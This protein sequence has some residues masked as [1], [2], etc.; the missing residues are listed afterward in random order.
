MS[1][2]ASDFPFPHTIGEPDDGSDDLIGGEGESELEDDPG[3]GGPASADDRLAE[4]QARMERI[5]TEARQREQFYQDQLA[6]QASGG[7]AGGGDA[8]DDLKLDDLPDPVEDIGK[9]REQLSARVKDYTTKTAKRVAD[10]VRSETSQQQAFENVWSRFRSQHEDLAE[11]QVLLRAAAM[12]EIEDAQSRGLDPATVI[13]RD[14]DGF[15]TRVADRMRSELGVSGEGGG[16]PN[17]GR[18]KGAS[19]GSRTTG[20]GGG[21]ARKPAGFAD[22][23]KK[24]QA[25]F[26]L[27]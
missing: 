1:T 24:Q 4:M 23:L 3:Q 9:F 13:Q 27:I 11:K 25:E 17:P 26:G 18:T 22:Q 15:I 7:A 20:K 16:K 14:S 6:K 21:G 5:E 12:A 10:S 8:E 2:A 19:G